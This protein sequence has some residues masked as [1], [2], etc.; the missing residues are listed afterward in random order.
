MSTKNKILVNSSQLFWL[1]G[2]KNTSIN[3]IIK[4]AEISKG[5][6]FHYF[7]DKKSLF[8]HVI[9]AFYHQEIKSSL[10]KHVQQNDLPQEQVLGFCFE[11]NQVY[12]ELNF[13]GGCLLGN[14]SLEL[15]DIDEDFRLKLDEVF[16]LWRKQLTHIIAKIPSKIDAQEI[17]DYVIWGIEGLTLTAKVHKDLSRNQSEF[18]NFIRILKILLEIK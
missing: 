4:K 2:Y 1:K 17:A 7:S 8:L 13:Q 6:F 10:D 16:L 15:S 12:Q 3:D 18:D 11:I 9:D 14:L 5:S